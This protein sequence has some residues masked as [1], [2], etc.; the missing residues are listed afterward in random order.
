LLPSDAPHEFLDAAQF[1]GALTAR[2]PRI[3]GQEGFTID[4][5]LPGA[6][7][8]EKRLLVAAFALKPLID[9]GMA[10]QIDVHVPK[11]VGGQS[12][13][14]C[15]AILS[16]R[17]AMPYG[18]ARKNPYWAAM[19]RTRNGQ[20]IRALIA[21]RITLAGQLLG[22][23]VRLDPRR[24]LEKGDI[25]PEHRVPRSDWVAR[26]KQKPSAAIEELQ[27][28]R[29][30]R[31]TFRKEL[32]ALRTERQAILDNTDREVL[33]ASELRKISPAFTPPPCLDHDAAA[34]AFRL[35]I[36][37]AEP[38]EFTDV[39]FD[40]VDGHDALHVNGAIIRFNGWSL[41]MQGPLSHR[42]AKVMVQAAALLD[43]PG[44]VVDGDTAFQE[45]V[46]EQAARHAKLPAIIVGKLGAS[47]D[48]RLSQLGE[49]YLSRM[50]AR[51][52]PIGMVI[53]NSPK[54]HARIQVEPAPRQG[55]YV[56]YQL[57]EKPHVQGE[58]S[59]SADEK[60]VERYGD[61][62]LL[63]PAPKPRLSK[64]P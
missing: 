39:R 56:A 13:P 3:D 1:R 59:V 32:A 31:R 30:E 57:D 6:L 10:A 36:N 14:H 27:M 45:A 15:H 49:A 48:A 11:A 42:A 29:K 64:M 28:M 5:S 24:A 44:L 54:P 52:D 55:G 19:M 8:P 46:A 34:W 18:F 50:V 4:F 12:Q 9:Q 60:R 38:G 16:Q 62:P 47:A 58:H 33:E 40:V 37:Q 26:R 17:L 7:R 21:A 20:Q 61:A 63:M 43:W 23:D 51:I 35:A 22:I 53:A 25:E 2:D 41:L